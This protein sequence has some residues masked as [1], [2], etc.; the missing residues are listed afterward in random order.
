MYGKFNCGTWEVRI[1]VLEVVK[2]STMREGK[3]QGIK[4]IATMEEHANYQVTRRKSFVYNILG[5]K[6][7][8]EAAQPL[9]STK[10]LRSELRKNVDA[11]YYGYRDEDDG[12]LLEYEEAQEEVSLGRT[13]KSGTG[14]PEEGW[15]AIGDVGGIPGQAEVEQWLVDRR[16]RKLMERYGG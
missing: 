13:I 1:M 6:E 9:P 3:S 12:L 11:D 4:G 7:L 15:N 10:K 2:L 14:E 8:F 16:K 5:V